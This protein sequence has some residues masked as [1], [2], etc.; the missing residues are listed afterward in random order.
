MFIKPVKLSIFLCEN[1]SAR[2][3]KAPVVNR[4]VPKITG[5]LRFFIVYPYLNYFFMFVTTNKLFTLVYI[6]H[7]I[8]IKTSVLLV[9]EEE[10]VRT[11]I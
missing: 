9:G 5:M 1:A 7:K 10:M 6:V 4:K 3:K 11:I 8:Q 2:A